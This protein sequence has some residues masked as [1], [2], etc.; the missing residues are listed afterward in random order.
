MHK[1]MISIFIN[2]YFFISNTLKLCVVCNINYYMDIIKLK[3][4]HYNIIITYIT[5]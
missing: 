2:N 3:E 4:K 1:M 5:I